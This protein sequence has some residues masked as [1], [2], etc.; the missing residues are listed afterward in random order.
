METSVKSSLMK[1]AEAPIQAD[2][3]LRRQAIVA[4]ILGDVFHGRLKPGQR[5]VTRELA[6]RFGVSHTPIRE[7]L[8]AVA[9][10]GLIDLNPNRG[11]V[12]REVTV[13]DV[14]EV[15]QV[16]RALECEAVRGACG[17][18][19]PDRLAV[20][21]A[22]LRSQID[23]ID[24]KPPDRID[25]ARELDSRLHDL[26]ARSCG[27]AFLA[28]E[29]N[30]LK[31]LFRAFRDLSWDRDIDLIQH[32]IAEESREHLAIVESFVA[33]DRAAAARAMSRHVMSGVRY[34]SIA[35]KR[36]PA[37]RTRGAATAKEIQAT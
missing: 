18:I 10:M 26:I 2:H 29:I 9:A 17:R 11:A 20:L 33:G 5:L 8:I 4:S 30:R 6:D 13:R 19:D 32:R 15:C 37:A 31:I 14:R 23:A 25:R 7:A 12:V 27:N 16:R 34:W 3:G 24:A 28:H 36:R 21:E 35:I 1:R 22:D